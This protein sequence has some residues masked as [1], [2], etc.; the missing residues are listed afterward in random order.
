MSRTSARRPPFRP[1]AL[2][3]LMLA[4]ALAGPA[5]PPA[6][7]GL[8][9]LVKKAKD[10]AAQAVVGKTTSGTPA[11]NAA[12]PPEFTDEL[13]ELTEPR[14][15]HV[16]KGLEAGNKVLAARAPLVEK[17]NRLQDEAAR[18]LDQHGKAMDAARAKHDAAER[19]WSDV[20]EE[21]TSARKE[22]MQATMMND[23]AMREKMM[24]LAMEMAEAQAAGDTAAMMK[25]QRQAEALTGPTREDSLAARQKCGPVPPLHA[26]D[27]K[28]RALRGETAAVEEQI[29]ANDEQ[30]VAAQVKASGLEPA[31]F[32]MARERLIMWLQAIRSA[33]S[34]TPRGFSDG[35]LAAFDARR[36]E[37]ETALA[38]WT[39]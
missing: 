33:K 28:V 8:G 13:L 35:E 15:G 1:V 11:A 9:D 6:R 30:S 17:R 34:G 36:A 4:F 38:A 22:Q 3:L 12:T 5:A 23:P 31:Q 27:V 2:A 18:L 37:I 29:R 21:K 25:L 10:K 20:L 16:M 7:A 24:A 14:L 26:M 19:C 39:N 32:A